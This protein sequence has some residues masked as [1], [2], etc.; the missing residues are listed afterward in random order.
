MKFRTLTE[1]NPQAVRRHSTE[2]CRLRNT[3]YLGSIISVLAACGL[4]SQMSWAPGRAWR[5]R[6]VVNV[7]PATAA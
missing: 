3:L 2:V 1:S 5:S 6:R 4:I 7:E